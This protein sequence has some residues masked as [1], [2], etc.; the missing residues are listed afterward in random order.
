MWGSYHLFP[1]TFVVQSSSSFRNTN[2]G[3]AFCQTVELSPL[4]VGM[5]G[6][7]QSCSIW[8]FISPAVA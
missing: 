3:S 7:D 6:V 4:M 1:H 2:C 8:E 5:N